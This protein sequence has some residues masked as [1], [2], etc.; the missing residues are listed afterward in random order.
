MRMAGIVVLLSVFLALPAIVTPFTPPCFTI[1]E[2]VLCLPGTTLP[3]HS[4]G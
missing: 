4:R 1:G 3:W 2:R